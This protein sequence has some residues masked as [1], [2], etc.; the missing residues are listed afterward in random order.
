MD[1]DEHRFQGPD[2][3]R[4]SPCFGSLSGERIQAMEARGFEKSLFVS[5]RVHL[6]LRWLEGSL[7]VA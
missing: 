3:T 1:T 4:A 7:R 6:W 5:I 2:S